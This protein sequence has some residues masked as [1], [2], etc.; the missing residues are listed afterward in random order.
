[1][2][3]NTYVLLLNWNGWSDT[4]ACLESLFK[5]TTKSVT[6]VVCDNA[7]SDD[8]LD[9]IKL[10]L[11]GDLSAP[12]PSNQ[13]KSL[14][15]PPVDKPIDWVEFDR[16]SAEKGGVASKVV[17]IQ[18]GANLGFAGGNNVG[19]RYIMARGDADYIWLLN[20]DTV[21]EPS[22][23]DELLEVARADSDIG[24]VGSSLCYFSNPDFLQARGGATFSPFR[25]KARPL[26]ENQ[27]R[28]P[29][30]ISE[31]EQLNKQLGYV[32]GAS[33]LVSKTF[34]DEVGL[35]S[36]DYFLYYEELDWACRAK[37]RFRLAVAPNSIV[38]HKVGASAGTSVS[39][40][41]IKYLYVNQIKFMKKFYPWWVWSV[42]VEML[43][44]ALRYMRQNR[45][46]AAKLISK[47]ALGLEV[48]S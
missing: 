15:T 19:L 43:R 11:N 46:D 30:S 3:K 45:Y 20:N 12:V 1:M 22:A 27:K 18:T 48:S 41:S 33:M 10:W 26:H 23:L 36:E 32:I 42:R 29:I 6:I 44:D 31:A 47:I 9:N 40:F 16:E 25:A 28:S 7:S 37:G 8:S 35:M 2:N 5:L 21:V 24:I 14:V 34:I 17:L 38:Y 13:L 4:V 39:L